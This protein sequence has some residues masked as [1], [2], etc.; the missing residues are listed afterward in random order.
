MS[1]DQT[2]CSCQ[3]YLRGNHIWHVE[4]Q[5]A[6]RPQLPPRVCVVILALHS[7]SYLRPCFPSRSLF[8]SGYT[9]GPVLVPSL[10]RSW[11]NL[12]ATHIAVALPSSCFPS[13]PPFSWL[14]SAEF[15]S[16]SHLKGRWHRSRSCG[17]GP[18]RKM[19]GVRSSFKT[20]GL[21]CEILSSFLSIKVMVT[22]C[23]RTSSLSPWLQNIYT[24]LSP[25][26]TVHCTP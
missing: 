9:S 1:K 24:V 15:L 4:C 2:H 21:V 10:L 23:M 25:L 5:C 14:L 3:T 26:C 18:P 12:S 22:A 8:T 6:S 7:V 16:S 19:T 13:A 11:P 20:W 17:L